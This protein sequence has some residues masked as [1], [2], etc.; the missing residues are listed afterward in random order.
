MEAWCDVVLKL[1]VEDLLCRMSYDCGPGLRFA[2]SSNSVGQR[3]KQVLVEDIPGLLDWMSIHV[4][5]ACG[6]CF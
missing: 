6:S 1:R 2:G 3:T 4:G 5:S